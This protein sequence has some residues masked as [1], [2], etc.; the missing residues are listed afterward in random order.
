MK[1]KFLLAGF[2]TLTG[3][4]APLTVPKFYPA[5][6]MAQ[7]NRESYECDKEARTFMAS[8]KKP[9]T[10][11]VSKSGFGYDVRPTESFGDNI[12]GLF[13]ALSGYPSADQLNWRNWYVYCMQ[14]RGHVPA[15]E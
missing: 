15:A 12:A 11:E 5:G 13:N 2:L 9:P 10:Y 8:Q 1:L 4:A 6:S 3:C 14:S 7:F